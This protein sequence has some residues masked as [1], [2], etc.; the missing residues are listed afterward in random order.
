[1]WC[2]SLYPASRLQIRGC[3]TV[4]VITPKPRCQLLMGPEPQHSPWSRQ[5]LPGGL[6]RARLAS[7][8][9]GRQMGLGRRTRVTQAHPR[10]PLLWDFPEHSPPED[11]LPS[12]TIAPGMGGHLHFLGQLQQGNVITV[13]LSDPLILLGKDIK[14]R[15]D[16]RLLNTEIFAPLGVRIPWE[17]Y[18]GLGWARAPEGARGQGPMVRGTWCGPCLTHI[19]SPQRAV[20]SIAEAVSGRQDPLV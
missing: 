13:E 11:A 10:C 1:M 3:C 20:L 7:T 5:V 14:P 6:R 18:G 17:K 4:R 16:H 15:G 2:W 19:D 8:V 9:Q 12:Q